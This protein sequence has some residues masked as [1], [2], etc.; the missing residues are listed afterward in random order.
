MNSHIKQGALEIYYLEDGAY[1]L[2]YSY[3]LQKDED[4]MDYNP[5]T[6]VRLK[7]FPHITMTL[8]EIFEG[9]D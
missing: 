3:I 7:G 5:E 4:D 6:S 2:K 8:A 9:T 1:T